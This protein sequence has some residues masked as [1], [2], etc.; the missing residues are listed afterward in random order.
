[1]RLDTRRLTFVF[2][3][4]VYPP[5]YRFTNE[6]AEFLPRAR[7]YF[8]FERFHM[9]GDSGGVL[10]SEAW[11]R[12]EIER[13][14]LSY[15]EQVNEDFEVVRRNAVD[16]M[17]LALHHFEIPFFVVSRVTLRQRW[18]MEPG[19]PAVL[20]V[21]REHA[22]KLEPGHFEPLG[23]IESVGLHLVGT[24]GDEEAEA[25]EGPV[26]DEAGERSF[27][28]HL[29]IDPFRTTENELFIQLGAEFRNPLDQADGIGE[30]LQASHDFLYDN[31]GKFIAG[32]MP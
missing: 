24:V 18:P 15:Q 30:A 11:K 23:P 28:W 4:L 3:R 13:S 9:D 22:L 2:F 7:E 1:M 6:I 31:G 26:T 20:D 27:H 10:E 29:E 12:L 19:D 25:D 21:M 32:F 17:T 16:L 5:L 8:P 14:K